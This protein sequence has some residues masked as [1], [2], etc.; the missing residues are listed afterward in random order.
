MWLLTPTGFFSIVRKPQDAAA[1]TLT[2]RSRVRADLDTKGFEE[3]APLRALASHVVE[4]GEK[5]AMP[6]VVGL[7]KLEN[8]CHADP[9]VAVFRSTGEEVSR[10]RR[11]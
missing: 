3:F 5:L 11:R 8:V 6:V 1:G 2:V 7:Q 9:S 4:R 10:F